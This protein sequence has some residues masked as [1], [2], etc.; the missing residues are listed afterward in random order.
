MFQLGL[1]KT[2]N[3]LKSRP[4]MQRAHIARRQDTTK[5]HAEG[6]GAQAEGGLDFYMAR[7]KYSFNSQKTTT[8]H[9]NKITR[10]NGSM[11]ISLNPRLGLGE[12]QCLHR[13]VN[14]KKK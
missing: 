3:I 14:S 8:F 10:S 13:H 1:G 5:E 11:T 12:F 6:S 4:G 7:P 2:H 9:H